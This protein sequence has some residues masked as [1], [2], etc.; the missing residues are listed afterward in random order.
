MAIRFAT[1]SY[2]LHLR[3][4]VLQLRRTEIA[5]NRHMGSTAQPFAQRFGHSNTATYHHHVDIL[6]RAFQEKVAH[7]AP[8]HVAGHVEFIGRSRN[9]LEYVVAEV[10]LQFIRCPISHTFRQN[11]VFG[12]AKVA[13][14][15]FFAKTERKINAFHYFCHANNP[16]NPR[17]NL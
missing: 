2:K 1:G 10:F 14:L 12:A 5:E 17:N 15:F 16:Y 13:K 6:R 3:T 9:L 11:H 4:A 8:H 7:V